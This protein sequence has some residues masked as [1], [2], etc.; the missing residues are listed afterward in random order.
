V[1]YDD[2]LAERVR[3][4]LD[5]VEHVVELKMFGGWGVTIRGNMAVGVMND[6]LIVRVGPEHFEAL[7]ERQ[8][9]RP[10]DFTGRAMTGWLYV[11]GSA[12][13]HGRSL[14]AWVDRGVAFAQSL[15]SKSK[16]RSKKA[17][18]RT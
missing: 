14:A 7:L 2:H 10:F 11:D 15:P 12:V 6:D 8:G 3:A 1:P 17:R 5:G 16:T 4:R 13:A 9:A 18:A